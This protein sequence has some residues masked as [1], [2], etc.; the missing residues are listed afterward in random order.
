MRPRAPPA[1]PPGSR[2]FGARAGW[3]HSVLF[4]GE[5]PEFRGRLPRDVRDD[6][7]AF[8]AAEKQA[9]AEARAAKKRRKAAKAAA[10]DAGSAGK[11][12]KKKK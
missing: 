11:N 1:P 8:A 7:A 2:R 4:A 5:L 3:A 9:K 6:M 10:V 12:K